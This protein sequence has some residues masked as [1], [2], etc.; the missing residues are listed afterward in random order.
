M[1]RNESLAVEILDKLRSHDIKQQLIAGSLKELNKEVSSIDE[2][3]AQLIS[4]QLRNNSKS[5]VVVS[6]AK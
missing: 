2:A 6:G 4:S 5:G 3:Y 1:D